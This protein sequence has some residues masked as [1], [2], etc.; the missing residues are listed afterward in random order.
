MV[1]DVEFQRR[2]YGRQATLL[3][4]EWLRG[5]FERI[6]VACNPGNEPAKCLYER[7]GFSH[8]GTNYDG[9]LLLELS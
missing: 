6:L 5:R 3:A 2:G 9:D 8:V 1:I 4:L 7:L